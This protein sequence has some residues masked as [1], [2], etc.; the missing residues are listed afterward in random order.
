MIEPYGTIIESVLHAFKSTELTI[1]ANDELKITL[2]NSDYFLVIATERYY[3]PSILASLSDGS[4]QKFEIGLAERILAPE[5]FES[6][7]LEL[8]KIRVQ[9]HLDT[10]GGD[11]HVRSSGI[12][13]YT[14]VAIRQ[15]FG[16]VSEFGKAIVRDNE[17]F[18]AEYHSREQKLLTEFGL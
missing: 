15:I 10:P 9:Y 16:F 12:Y 2:A 7:V 5:R 14:K 18:R 11:A 17:T 13:I 3:Q 8:N 4:D 6:D 1:R